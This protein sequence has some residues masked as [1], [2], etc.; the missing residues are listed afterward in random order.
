MI[1]Q[2]LFRVVRLLN[3]LPVVIFNF[4]LGSSTLR[5]ASLFLGELRDGLTM[6][7][8]QSAFLI[9][10]KVWRTILFH[11]MDNA[12]I[13]KHTFICVFLPQT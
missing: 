13:T 6:I 12:C 10:S 3:I 5:W 2:F 9:V 11:R 1:D 7:N 8:M 4:P